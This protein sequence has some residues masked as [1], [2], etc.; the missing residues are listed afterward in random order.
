MFLM[1]LCGSNGLA[2]GQYKPLSGACPLMVAS[3]K[4]AKGAMPF[5][6]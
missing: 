1:N 4:L 2:S 3:L 5:V 6:L